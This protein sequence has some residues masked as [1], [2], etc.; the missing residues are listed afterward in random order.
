MKEEMEKTIVSIQKVKEY[1]PLNI[2]RGL[3]QCFSLQGG[4]ETIIKPG[5]KVFVKINHLSPPSSPEEAIIT[6]PLFTKEVVRLLLDAGCHV[7]VG[8][9]IHSK[10]QDGFLISGYRNV[11]NDLGVR[12]LNLKE[13]GFRE[14]ECKGEVLKKA[15][16]SSVVLDADYI[17]NLPKLKN[18]SFM[19]YTGAIKNMYGII[20]HGL[21]CSH[22]RQFFLPETFSQMLVDIFS[23]AQPHLNIMDAIV[24]MEGEGPSAGKPRHLGLILA[25]SD[26]V[27]LDAVALR[28]IGMDPMQIP[29]IAHAS[30]R[31]CGTSDTEKIEIL[32]ERIQDIEIKDFKP[33]AIAA[34]LIKKRIPAL[35]HAFIQD[36]LIL[37][38]EVLQKNCTACRE[39]SDACPTG[40]AQIQDEEGK[41]KIDENRCIRC[42]CCHEVCRFHAIELKE[43][44]FGR[45]LRGM[46]ATYK[47]VMSYLS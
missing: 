38:P 27:A 7:T 16:I 39:C 19:A 18:H 37:I 43:K 26:A 31:G 5:S 28:I 22:H 46:N 8:D 41:A 35:I 34:G 13:L 17:I 32:G 25:S 11:C 20:P 10:N 47:K 1:S 45:L 6:H 40:A 3:I 44:A 33:S 42:M 2:R 9:D 29:I 23:C 36:Q 12:L 14:V 30:K 15:F 4:L 24:A 21:R